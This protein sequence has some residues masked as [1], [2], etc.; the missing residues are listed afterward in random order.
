MPGATDAD[1]RKFKKDIDDGRE[2]YE[3]EI[4]YK[5]TEYEFEID[6]QTGEIIK[7]ESEAIND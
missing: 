4:I 2:E 5:N 7:W 3:G 1:I 6:A